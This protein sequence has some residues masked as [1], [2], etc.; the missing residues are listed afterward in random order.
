MVIIIA[1]AAFVFLNIII[2]T[3]IASKHRRSAEQTQEQQIPIDPEEGAIFSQQTVREERKPRKN[4]KKAAEQPD[5]TRT[6]P[7][8]RKIREDF[9]LVDN[10]I[11]IHTNERL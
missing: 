1:T 2:W 8:E 10:I 9:R 6:V 11:M 4:A 5:F 3:F 7:H